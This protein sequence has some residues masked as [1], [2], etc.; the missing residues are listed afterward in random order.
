MKPFEKITLPFP[1]AGCQQ[2]RDSDPPSVYTGLG[3]PC[4]YEGLWKP[5]WCVELLTYI[6]KSPDFPWVISRSSKY[7]F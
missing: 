2:T 7:I 3:T 5:F 1:R 4:P 6:S